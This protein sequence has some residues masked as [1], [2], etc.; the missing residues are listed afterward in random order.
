MRERRM[1]MTA[2]PTLSDGL[3]RLATWAGLGE[4]TAVLGVLKGTQCSGFS[5]IELAIVLLIVGLLL[6][7][8]LVPLSTR[9]E[10]TYR[11]ETDALLQ[12]VKESLY[13]YAV[14]NGRLLC[15]DCRDGAGNCSSVPVADLNDG[16]GDL[17]EGECATEEGNLPWAELGVGYQDAWGQ[18]LDYRVT[19]LFARDPGPSFSLS[20]IGDITVK[21]PVGATDVATDIPA[22][23]VSHGKNWASLGS[24]DEQENNGADR[25][26][27]YRGYARDF[28][29]L[30]IWLSP[31]VLKYRMVAAGR[32]P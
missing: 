26:Y 13:G 15:P 4:R 18:P 24:T 19:K 3:S 29:D 11:Q 20:D 25:V 22:I 27:V 28:D 10:A 17:S 32:L 31:H 9:I 2:S 6:G 30:L 8:L 16:Q 1:P 23:V 21:D 7:G 5:L 12:E 14:V